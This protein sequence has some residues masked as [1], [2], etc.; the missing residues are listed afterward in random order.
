MSLRYIEEGKK[1]FLNQ[2]TLITDTI[3]L[4]TCFYLKFEFYRYNV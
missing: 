3:I 4:R 2:K 1:T